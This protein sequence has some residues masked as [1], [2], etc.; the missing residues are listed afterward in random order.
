MLL[1]SDPI[2]L[3]DQGPHL[4]ATRHRPMPPGVQLRLR[5]TGSSLVA[6]LLCRGP[7]LAPVAKLLLPYSV[8]PTPRLL[9]SS[10]ATAH[11][12]CARVLAA[13]SRFL[14]LKESLRSH[15]ALALGF[16]ARAHLL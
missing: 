7:T 12:R 10:I 1:Q 5:P 16:A 4:S 15:G 13:P 6:E 3:N 8:F 2:G 9:C 14:S 11:R